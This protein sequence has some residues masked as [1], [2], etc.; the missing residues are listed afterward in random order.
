MALQSDAT[1]SISQSEVHIR[2]SVMG[3]VGIFAYS[4]KQTGCHLGED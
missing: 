3:R 1:D 4:V 2:G